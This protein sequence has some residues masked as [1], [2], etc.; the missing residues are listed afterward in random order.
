MEGKKGDEGWQSPVY[1]G[2]VSLYRRTPTCPSSVVARRLHLRPL[3]RNRWR[4]FR[5]TQSPL[6]L[7][8]VSR[9]SLSL[10][11]SRHSR[12]FGVIGSIGFGRG[13]GRRNITPQ[14]RHETNSV[15]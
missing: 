12:R 13:P 7:T 14:T 4:G 15:A 5:R 10:S 2:G 9:F 11:L 6:R 1:G 3:L 8:S